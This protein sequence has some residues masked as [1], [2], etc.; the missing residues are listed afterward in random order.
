MLGKEKHVLSCTLEDENL[1]TYV[2]KILHVRNSRCVDVLR[3]T[4]V[5]MTTT[6]REVRSPRGL[7]LGN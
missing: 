7:A 1:C 4:D 2:C 5:S 6:V 3:V